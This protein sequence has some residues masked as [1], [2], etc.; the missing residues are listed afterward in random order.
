MRTSKFTP[1]QG[2]GVPVVDLLLK[3]CLLIA[4]YSVRSE[5]QFCER[6]HPGMVRGVWR[7]GRRA[8]LGPARLRHDR[9]RA[10]H[11]V[12]LNITVN[13]ERDR[14]LRHDRRR[15][16]GHRRVSDW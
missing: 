8:I 2:D 5:R 4:L 15:S 12:H 7:P 9:R 1:D 16:A 3:S 11:G 6:L 10:L 14:P 13:R